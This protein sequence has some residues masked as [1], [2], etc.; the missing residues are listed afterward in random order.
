MDDH[1]LEVKVAQL[2]QKVDI[3]ISD[4]QGDIKEIKDAIQS[5]NNITLKMEYFK[6]TFQ[7]LF[8]RLER[9]EKFRDEINDIVN[10]AKGAKVMTVVLWSILTSG[11]ITI[12]IKVF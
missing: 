11:L 3:I 1:Q 9:L 6:E 2:G 7:R 4:I 10:Q 12:A 5:V 8:E